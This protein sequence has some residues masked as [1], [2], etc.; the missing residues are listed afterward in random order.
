[1]DAPIKGDVFLF[2]GFR[3]DRRTGRLDRQD[4]PGVFAKVAIGARALDV[5]GVLVERAGE[6]TPKNEII[7]A[8][9]PK[10]S[11]EGG[12][13]TVQIAALRRVLDQGRL[14][15]SCIQTVARRGYR[16]VLPVTR[17]EAVPG[18]VATT[19][20]E[21]AQPVPRLS[22]VVLPFANLSGDPGQEYFADGITDDL[23][24]DLSRID[25]SFVIARSTAFAYKG[26]SIDVKQ[27][28]RELGVRYVLEGSVRR[29]GGCIR[30]NVQLID[31]ETGGHLWAE[32]LD[33]DRRNLAEAEDEITSRLARTLN[34]QLVE[35]VGRRIESEKRIDPGARDLAMC[36][37]AWFYRPRSPANLQEAQE[38][39][40]RALK[41]DPRSIEAKVGIATVCISRLLGGWSCSLTEDQARAE[42]LLVE[43]LARDPNRSMA[44]H[45]MGMLRRSQNRL[46][47]AQL[48]LQRALALNP[49]DAGAIYQL[50]LVFMYQGQ[51]G[52]AITQIEKAIRLSPR[53]H[54][55]SAM[56]YGLGRC[57]VFL[58]RMELAI[59]LF[60]RVR[61]TDPRHWDNRVWLA[62][63]LGLTGDNERARAELAEAKLLNPEIDTLARWRTYQP[64]ITY[65]EY[66]ALRGKTLY[67]GLRAAGMPE[68]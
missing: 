49:Y 14:E 65:P 64:W 28:S 57:L 45:A 39:F 58:G 66:E 10:M 32:R 35:V 19:L 7:A 9:W 62:G 3:L 15:G 42:G 21:G 34:L 52:A 18:L 5:L 33:T 48:A 2:E 8:V 36:G 23:T 24:T 16:F 47:E 56:Y 63:A 68:K 55:V 1:M 41:V 53:D 29:S 54:L 50:G 61:M 27:V 59:E 30:I 60:D 22:I 6:I 46:Q 67:V 37:W 13:L 40:E 43:V 12:N 38:H 51:P 17:V 31:G 44:H 25:E 11:V 4:R 20:Q 26:K